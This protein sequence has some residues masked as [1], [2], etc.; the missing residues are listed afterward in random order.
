MRLDQEKKD[1]EEK[2][3]MEEEVSNQDPVASEAKGDLS[4]RGAKEDVET[5][6]ETEEGAEEEVLEAGIKN[7]KLTMSKCTRCGKERIVVSS[8]TKKVDKATVTYTVTVCPDPECQKMVDKGLVVEEHKRKM[9]REE[10]DKRA[11]EIILKKKREAAE[12]AKN[13]KNLLKL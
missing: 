13:A 2:A 8:Q 6:V 7:L 4:A 10:Q 11:Q 9:I 1:Q 3:V 5:S 12:K